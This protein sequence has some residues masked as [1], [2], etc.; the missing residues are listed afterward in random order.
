MSIFNRMT[1]AAV[2]FS[3]SVLG[4]QAENLRVG[5]S[6]EPYPPFSSLDSSG[7][8][9]G[10]EIEIIDAVCAAAKFECQITPVAWDGIIPSLTSKKIDVIMSSMSIT[11]ERKK[12]IDF[13]DKYYSD[14]GYTVVGPK[15]VAVEPTAEGL[16]GKILGVQTSTNAQVYASRHFQDSVAQLKTYQTE[17]EV[18]Q[19]LVA[20]RIDAALASRITISEF[21]NTDQG[22]GCCEVKGT[23]ANDPEIMARGVGAGVRKGDTEIL[24]KINAGIKAIRDNGKYAEISNRYFGFD[25]YGD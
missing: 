14:N 16:K 18:E 25:I 4:A 2:A 24:E 23:V 17:D 1:L 13:S 19:D 7:K 8:W 9:V 6:A 10:W 20:G 5:I 22:K 3:T 15:G 11:K 12:T 21:L